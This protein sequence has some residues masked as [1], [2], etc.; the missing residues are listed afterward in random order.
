MP[1]AERERED[2]ELTEQDPRL[3]YDYEGR[4]VKQRLERDRMRMLPRVVKPAMFA[5]GGHVLGDVRVF[6]RFTVGPVSALTCRF[7]ELGP[8]QRSPEERRIPI[9]TMYVLEG[10]GSWVHEGAEHT[11]TA[12]DVVVV[13]PYTRHHFAA[14]PEGFRG[15]VPETRFWHV[16]G[17]LWHEHFEGQPLPGIEHRI[18]DDGG[19]DGYRVP[20]GVLGLEREIEV[21][22]GADPRRDAV[23]RARRAVRDPS[24]F[25]GTTWYDDLLRRLPEDNDRHDRTPPVIRGSECPWEDTR[26]GRMKFYVS[27]WTGLAGQDL[28]L[29]AYEIPPGGRTGRHRHIAE[30]ILLV[31]RGS[32]FDDHDGSEHR[33]EEGD[34]ICIPPMA[35]HLHANDGEEPARLVSVWS[36]HPA[37]EFLGGFEHIDDAVGGG[38][39]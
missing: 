4:F 37:N 1:E 14:G 38:G 13:P 30:E 29:A 20:E 12:E 31:V 18:G 8:G 11:F 3:Y 17:L 15:W 16:L 28:D 10:S 9:L 34:L 22:A 6:E 33:W 27:N 24:A 36:H 2:L 25:E 26:G 39:P 21:P 19:W 5:S 35:A 23:F 32:G 7:L